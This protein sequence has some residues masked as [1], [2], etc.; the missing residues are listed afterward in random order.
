GVDADLA[1][2]DVVEESAQQR[3]QHP[4]GGAVAHSVRSPEVRGER[5]FG[6]QPVEQDQADSDLDDADALAVARLVGEPAPGVTYLAHWS[7][8]VPLT[9]A[10]RGAPAWGCVSGCA[11][12]AS[13]GRW[14]AATL[15]STG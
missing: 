8:P 4:A 15:P 3:S 5:R 10:A 6:E 7:P 14:S 1:G 13:R 11:G 12:R 2:V 9:S